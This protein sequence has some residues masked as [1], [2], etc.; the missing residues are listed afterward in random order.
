MSTSTILVV[1]DISSFREMVRSMLEEIGFY[2]VHDAVDGEQALTLLRSC[3]FSLVI[4]DYMMSPKNGIDLLRGMKD[5]QMFKQ[6]PFVLISAVSEQTIV[7]EAMSLGATV[8][9]K[10]PLGFATFKKEILSIF[11]AQMS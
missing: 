8:C 10:K 1:D 9:L 5:D 2:D 3:P 6:I 4:S 7:S 11:A